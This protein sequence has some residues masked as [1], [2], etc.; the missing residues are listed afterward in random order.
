MNSE[1]NA[2]RLW[3]PVCGHALVHGYESIL[4][5]IYHKRCFYWL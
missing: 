2:R 3:C 5:G 4:F 1:P